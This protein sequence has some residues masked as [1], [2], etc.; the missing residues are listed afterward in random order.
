[1]QQYRLL[2]LA[3]LQQASGRVHGRWA[4]DGKPRRPAWQISLIV[5]LILSACA[6][7]AAVGQYPSLQPLDT[8]LAEADSFAPD[9]GPAQV[10]RARQ[11]QDRVPGP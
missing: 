1:M 11:L 3:R 6:N 10:E 8:L 7:S 2:G 5:C 4:K 9:P